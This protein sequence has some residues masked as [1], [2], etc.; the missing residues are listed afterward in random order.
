M[1]GAA[2]RF[3]VAAPNSFPEIP[4]GSGSHPRVKVCIIYYHMIEKRM[5]APYRLWQ[6]FNS[7]CLK[8]L[9]RGCR[10][11]TRRKWAELILHALVSK[12]MALDLDSLPRRC[13]SREFLTL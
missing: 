11:M 10:N 8:R 2:A 12:G 4:S 5:S 7:G 1:F 9:G 3:G 13:I 6:L